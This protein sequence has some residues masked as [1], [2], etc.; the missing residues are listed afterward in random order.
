MT[1]MGALGVVLGCAQ[2]PGVSQAPQISAPPVAPSPRRV[3]LRARVEG[4][5]VGLSWEFAHRRR[6]LVLDEDASSE[7]PCGPH[8]PAALPPSPMLGASGATLDATGVLRVR[9]YVWSP[10]LGTIGSEELL[11]SVEHD[12]DSWQIL[13]VRAPCGDLEVGGTFKSDTV[14][15]YRPRARLRARDDEF[16]NLYL[17]PSSRRADVKLTLLRGSGPVYLALVPGPDTSA[18]IRYRGLHDVIRDTD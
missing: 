7:I 6:T 13:L 15:M 3:L 16:L 18:D 14:L 8:W 11:L 9:P 5:S 2:P 10:A 12:L 4:F 17:E 1:L